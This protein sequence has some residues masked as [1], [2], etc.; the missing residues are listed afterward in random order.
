LAIS[1][2]ASLEEAA[3]LA[4]QA[5]GIKVGKLGTASVS[6]QELAEKLGG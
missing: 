2:G 1:A 5:A 6:K 3:L 4:N